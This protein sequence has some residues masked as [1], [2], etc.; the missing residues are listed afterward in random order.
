DPGVRPKLGRN[1]VNIPLLN[2][3]NIK[4]IRCVPQELLI[5]RDMWQVVVVQTEQ[6]VK[7]QIE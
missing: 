2:T 7:P 5:Y 1:M 4:N 3:S 6:T